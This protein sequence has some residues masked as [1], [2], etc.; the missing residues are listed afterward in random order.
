[1]T[2]IKCTVSI[3]TGW[4]YLMQWLENVYIYFFIGILIIMS[5][6]INYFKVLVWYLLGTYIILG[7]NQMH[8]ECRY[9]IE[10]PNAVTGECKHIFYIWIPF[11]L[12]KHV[13]RQQRYLTCFRIWWPCCA[14]WVWSIQKTG[15]VFLRALPIYRKI[16]G[17]AVC[18][19]AL[20]EVFKLLQHQQAKKFFFFFKLGY[21]S[22][23]ARWE[24]CHI[25]K[26]L[27]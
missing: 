2:D 24:K 3:D 23:V 6:S 21:L 7:D 13:K 5:I 9:R 20:W 25:L 10:V 12:S 16:S 8:S 15:A 18:H 1:M 22:C 14:Y 26:L 4:R 17:S 19:C 11:V 27:Q